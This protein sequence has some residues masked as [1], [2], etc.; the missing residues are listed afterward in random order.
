[1]EDRNVLLCGSRQIMLNPLLL[2]FEN[3]G[4]VFKLVELMVEGKEDASKSPAI[5]IRR[6]TFHFVL[7]LVC[8]E[9]GLFIYT[10]F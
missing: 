10:G 7:R 2:W 9:N 1:M 4:K 3:F 8:N 5:D 6:Y